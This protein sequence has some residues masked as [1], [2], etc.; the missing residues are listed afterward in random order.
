[1]ATVLDYTKPRVTER[2]MQTALY[3]SRL[4]GRHSLIVPNVTVLGWESDLVSVTAAGFLCEYEIKISRS[5]FK[6]DLEKSRHQ[7]LTR[8]L[9]APIPGWLPDGRRLGANYLSYVVPAGLVSVDE[10]PRYAG[11]ITVASTELTEVVRK[12]PRL[13]ATKLTDYQRAWLERSL[14]HRFWNQRIKPED[15][16]K[17]RKSIPGSARD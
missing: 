10:V 11:L 3:F 12:A 9:H 7:V 17:L 4:L 8:F 5:D 6:K 2:S 15:V 1:M 14:T 13:H 16:W